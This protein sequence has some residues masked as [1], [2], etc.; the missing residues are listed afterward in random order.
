MIQRLGILGLLISLPSFA[1][2]LEYT[3]GHRHS[4][5]LFY[6][7]GIH[8][9][10]EV[11]PAF[12]RRDYQPGF[13][14]RYKYSM[15]PDPDYGRFGFGL[16][17]S[18]ELMHLRQDEF[19]GI[20]AGVVPR[21]IL[22]RFWFEVPISLALQSGGAKGGFENSPLDFFGITAGL[23]I[24]Y[25]LERFHLGVLGKALE[26]G[27]QEFSNDENKGLKVKRDTSFKTGAYAR[28][29]AFSKLWLEYQ[30]ERYKLGRTAIA[31]KQFGV[32][33]GAESLFRNTYNIAW[34]DRRWRLK[35]GASRVNDVRDTISL[36]YQHP[37]MG[38][39]YLLSQ[40][41]AR[42]EFEWRF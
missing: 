6:A 13:G 16:L 35:L 29:R 10:T 1:N 22:R 39:D 17:V 15:N 25:R 38:E 19:P 40:W 24:S 12:D 4:A 8:Q 34:E 32:G 2:E 5:G 7:H 26:A 28:L 41:T 11:S 37:W 30:I 20:T 27:S 36:I 31:A 42:G 9:Y 14:L 33:I 3:K 21:F 23:D 18:G